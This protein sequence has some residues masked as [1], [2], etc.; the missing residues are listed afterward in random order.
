[1]G[2]VP[3]EDLLGLITRN[4]AAP[5]VSVGYNALTDLDV[6]DG[7]D[8]YQARQDKIETILMTLP[9]DYRKQKKTIGGI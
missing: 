8:F 3:R 7:T 5:N 6:S 2:F 1:M 9:M 4:Y